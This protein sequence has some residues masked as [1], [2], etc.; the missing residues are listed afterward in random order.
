MAAAKKPRKKTLKIPVEHRVYGPCE[1]V[2]AKM[3]DSGPVLAVRFA[4]GTTRS[5]LAAPEFWKTPAA[6]LAA[7]PMAKVA[8]PEPEPEPEDEPDEEVEAEL[9]TKTQ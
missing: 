4:D 6:Q 1:V 9:V 8:A 5:L 7:I 3:M 2:E